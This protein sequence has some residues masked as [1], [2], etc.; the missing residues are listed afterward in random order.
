MSRR[1]S[2]RFVSSI[3]LRSL[4]ACAWSFSLHAEGRCASALQQDHAAATAGD[5][6]HNI[7]LHQDSLRQST[8]GRNASGRRST[9]TCVS[10]RTPRSRPPLGQHTLVGRT[11]RKYQQRQVQPPPAQATRLRRLRTLF[12]HP[13][14][15]LLTPPSLRP[16]LSPLSCR[17]SA[18][19]FLSR[20]GVG[21]SNAAGRSPERSGVN[22][23]DG[24]TNN[25]PSVDRSYGS[26]DTSRN[27]SGESERGE[28]SSAA[29]LTDDHGL[30]AK[31]E[32][33]AGSIDAAGECRPSVCPF[34][35]QV[36][37]C[38]SRI[39]TQENN[40]NLLHVRVSNR[41]VS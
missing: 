9:L 24:G 23:G 15:P 10:Q 40:I 5:T 3:A 28:D 19:L 14:R 41:Q 31:A 16:S 33:G 39:S 37:K 22:R 21:S 13:P 11:H 32:E 38:V 36:W 2:H 8:D 27:S 29:A 25:V 18:R 4:L 34:V 12:V 17:S 20:M 7:L 26:V 35:V 1:K 30:L 6:R